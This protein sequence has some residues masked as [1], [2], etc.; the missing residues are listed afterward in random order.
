MG[1]NNSLLNEFVKITNDRRNV[2]NKPINI[3]GTI[4]TKQDMQFVKIDGSDI[5][6]PFRTTI[7][8]KNEERVVLNIENHKAIVTGNLSDP[9]SSGDRVNGIALRVDDAEGNL[10]LIDMSL[11]GITST[12]KDLDGKYTSVKQTVD[13]VTTTVKDLDG[14]YTEIKQTVDGIDVTGMVTFKDLS[15]S[16]G[17]TVIN[18]NNIT[19]GTID[20]VKVRSFSGNRGVELYSGY[21]DFYNGSTNIGWM[22]YDTS[23][24]GTSGE[25]SNRLWLTTRNGY[26]MKLQSSGDM[27]I[28]AGTEGQGTGTV[29][30]K[31]VRIDELTVNSMNAINVYAKFG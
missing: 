8:V 17:T 29:W 3:Y 4:V 18:G 23:G 15:T 21:V 24:P 16:N 12:V 20:G 5:L 26:A 28:E 10:A 30:M 13:D 19:T 7:E 11:N 14:K 22:G 6:T 25:A 1:V 9:S 27:S 31:K 2:D